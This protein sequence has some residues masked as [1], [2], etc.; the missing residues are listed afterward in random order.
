QCCCVAYSLIS[1]KKDIGMTSRNGP[2]MRARDRIACINLERAS[3]GFE[4]TAA[5]RRKA[6]HSSIPSAPPSM[7]ASPKLAIVKMTRGHHDGGTLAGRLWPEKSFGG[8][9][10]R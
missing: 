9:S 1:T 4:E 3:P 2:L 5:P 7:R 8:V 10:T 6:T